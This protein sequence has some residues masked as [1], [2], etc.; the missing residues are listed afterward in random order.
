MAQKNSSDTLNRED[1]LGRPTSGL[2]RRA[3]KKEEGIEKDKRPG[4]TRA[5]LLIFLRSNRFLQ[6]LRRDWF[7]VTALF[8]IFFLG[9]FLRSYFYYDIAVD[10]P[11]PDYDYVLSGNDP[12][13]HKQVIDHVQD[14]GGHLYRDPMLNYP[15]TARNPYPPIYDWSVAVTGMIVG[16]ATGMGTE[17]ATWMVLL[18]A[19][20][21]WGAL[22]IFPVYFL[23]RNIFGKQ[24]GLLSAFFMAIMPSHIERSPLGFSDHDAIVLFFVVTTF[25]FLAKA[26]NH[27]KDKR[28]VERWRSPRSISLGV[29]DFFNQNRIAVGF[30]LLCGF[31]IG[32]I[33]LMWKGFPYVMVIIA[34]FFV[35]QLLFNKFRKID[36]LGLFLII[37]IVNFSAMMISFP[38]AFQLGAGTWYN[39]FFIVAGIVVIGIVFVPTRDIPWIIVFPIIIIALALSYSLINFIFPEQAES[40]FSG[41]GYFIKSKLYETIAEAQAP[42][43]SRLVFSY[44]PVTFYM[45]LIG[46]VLAIIA[47]PRHWNTDYIL[48]TIWCALAIYMAMSAVRFMF[49]AS[50]V[51][52]ILTGWTIWLIIKR[53]DPTMRKFKRFEAKT[54][55]LYVGV[56]TGISLIVSFYLTY[57][58]TEEYTYF[59]YL[60]GLCAFGIAMCLAGLYLSF[61]FHYYFALLLIGGFAAI[62]LLYTWFELEKIFYEGLLLL[63]LITIPLLLFLLFKYTASGIRVELK[64]IGLATFFT[65]LV[66][67]PNCWFAMDSAIPYESKREYDPQNQLLGAFGHS[68]VS[69]YWLD[70]MRWLSEQDTDLPKEDRPGFVSWWDYGFWAIYLGEH[71][72]CAENFQNGYH[73]A[74]SVIASQNETEAITLFSLRLIES[75]IALNGGTN[76]ERIIIEYL[77]DGNQEDH[78]NWDRLNNAMRNPTDYISEV[79]DNPDTYGRYTGLKHENAKYAVGRVLIMNNLN[80]ESIVDMYNDLIVA[81]GKSIRYFAVDSRLFPFSASNTGIFYAPIKLADRDIDDYLEYLCN[82]EYR[83]SA[84]TEDWIPYPDN[85][86]TT[87]RLEEEI[88]SRGQDLVRILNWELRYKDEFYNTMFYRCFTGWHGSDI[89]LPDDSIPGIDDGVQS[90]TTDSYPAMQ[91]WGMKHF[92]LVYRTLYWNPYNQT[93]LGSDEE[94][95]GRYWR[96]TSYKEGVEHKSTLESDGIDNNNNNEIDEEGEGGT[97]SQGPR[98]SVYYLKYYHGALVQ[99]YVRTAPSEDSPDAVGRP[100]PNARVTVLD[101]Y[102]IPHDVVYTDENGWYNLTVPPGDITIIVSNGGEQIGDANTQLIRVEQ[103]QLNATTMTITDDQAMRRHGNYIISNDIRIEPGSLNGTVYWDKNSNDAYDSADEPP[104]EGVKVFLYDTA[105]V[106]ADEETLNPHFNLETVTDENGFY[107]FDKIIPGSYKLM[108]S[109]ASHNITYPEDVP[110]TVRESKMQ[111]FGVK[112][113]GIKGLVSYFNGTPAAN[114]TLELYDETNEKTTTFLSLPN[115]TFGFEDLLPGNYSLVVDWLGYQ[116]METR[117]WIRQGITNET[118][119]VLIPIT[120]VRGNVWYDR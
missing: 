116:R 45:S 101:D 82:A 53:V 14:T 65:F 107:Q 72:S 30:A 12:Y 55:Y 6:W 49:N 50:P 63:G 35:V 47:I 86:L 105:N 84:Q 26:F 3:G 40:L 91:G 7:T 43:L 93:T 27:L 11:Y 42:D 32:V 51:F 64:H 9:L 61:R 95:Y 18:F 2:G 98:S 52:A 19:P 87:D 80:L 21:F 62:W 106:D 100:I 38:I 102:M 110:F 54:M 70:G 96:A 85:P 120:P 111:D 69:E 92:K 71:P 109:I 73:F 117:V 89:G 76:S 75:D 29:R 24:A 119:V 81:T 94:K 77:D 118:D 37:I 90:T 39:P 48:I 15:V 104:I 88:D 4:V 16:G 44:G 115:G 74:G 79:M 20:A 36:S 56:V 103:T 13:Y 41:G 1:K 8:A 23:T 34:G 108:T 78:P 83:L 66:L 97:I 22:T 68:F 25:F 28:W 5:Q 10:P 60:F 99:G 113:G 31:S 17:D 67:M 114:I 58:Y 59:Q 112:P 33:A 46:L 57:H